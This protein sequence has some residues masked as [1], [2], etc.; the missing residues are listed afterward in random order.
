VF[1]DTAGA[2][3]GRGKRFGYKNQNT[4][5]QTIRGKIDDFQL[6]IFE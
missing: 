4:Y 6:L 1:P 3:S 5:Q 2:G